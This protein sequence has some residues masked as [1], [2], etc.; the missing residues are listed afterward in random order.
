MKSRSPLVARSRRDSS[1]TAGE[2]GSPAAYAHPLVAPQ[3]THL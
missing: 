2:E 1:K 3:L